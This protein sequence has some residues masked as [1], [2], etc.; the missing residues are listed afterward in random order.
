MGHITISV[1]FY[2]DTTLCVCVCGGGEGGGGAS[3]NAPAVLGF[4]IHMNMYFFGLICYL[5]FDHRLATII[6][7]P[8][9]QFL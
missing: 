7:I 8:H 9:I 3:I 2:F 1:G 6:R 5:S 4:R